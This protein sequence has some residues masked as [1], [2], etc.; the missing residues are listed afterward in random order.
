MKISYIEAKYEKDISLPEDIIKKLPQKTGIFT[1]L[2]FIDSLPEIKKQIERAGKKALIFKTTHTK[3]PGQIYGCNMDK[4]PGADGFLYI[5]DGFFHPKAIIIGNNKPVHSYNPISGEYKLYTRK[6]V[7]KD[8][9]RQK[10]AFSVFMTKK[11]I[12]VLVST[13]LGQSYPALA[14]KL[15]KDFPDKN[16]YYIAFDTVD[17]KRIND[18]PFIEA[19]VNT[20][21]PRIGW[22]DRADK[23]MV[24]M[25]TIYFY[26]TKSL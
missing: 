6:D 12:G 13:K 26:T 9:L 25:Q 2:Q 16:F 5:G 4:F 18:F 14:F 17:L 1:T 11:N 3:N 20:A 19:I 23:P 10:A 22:D 21:C 7:Q 8:F 24:D 15:E